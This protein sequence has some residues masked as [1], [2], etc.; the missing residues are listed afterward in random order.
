MDTSQ[1]VI[2]LI[3]FPF[4][5]SLASLSIRAIAIRRAVAVPAN[6]VLVG[7]TL[8][9]LSRTPKDPLLFKVE[10]PVIDHLLPF[11][12]IAIGIL[13]L[14]LALR[15]R[16]TIVALLA[17][18]Q[19]ALGLVFEFL[20]ASAAQ[21]SHN[22]FV[23][24]F[25]ILMAL[26][27]G[28]LGTLIASYGVGYMAEYHH[29][30]PEVKDRR[31]FFGF[32]IY[33]FLSAMF[34]LVFSNN[35]KWIYLFWEVT[36]LCSFFLIGYRNDEPSQESA[37]LALGINLL[38]GIAFSAGILYLFYHT[39]ILE[40]DRMVAEGKVYALIP[41]AL[42]A[43]AGLAKSAQMPFSSWLTA[44]MI[45]PT[46]V[47]ALLHSS[48]MVKAGVYLILKVSPLLNG[49][50]AGIMLTFVGGVT[51]L[52]ASFIAISQ[53]NAKR[54]LAYSTIS[55]LGLIVMCAGVG[56]YE[57]AWSALLLI[58]F[59]AVAKSLL[60]LCVGVV[61]YKLGSRDIEDMDFLIVRMPKVAAMMNI[62]LAGMFLAPFGMLISKAVTL[63]ALVDTHP[64]LGVI[65]AFGSGGTLFF[66]AKWMGKMITSESGLQSNEDR[67]SPWEWVTMV[68]LSGLTIAVCLLFPVI[69]HGLVD[70]Y[71]QGVYGRGPTLERLNL[72][73]IVGI[74]VSLLV[75]FPAGLL[76]QSFR[77][78]Y[79]FVGP[80]LSGGNLER[81]TFL[82]AMDQKRPV[83]SRNYYLTSIFGEARLLRIGLFL[84]A[85]FLIVMFGGVLS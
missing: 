48:T 59:H 41:A 42:L 49:T 69:T 68:S 39:G 6:L 16:R 29:H 26:I 51:F 47:S 14:Y 71:I 72:I 21:V 34:G 3:L 79:R 55:T 84:S 56:T 74:M 58:L 57:A 22:L 38:G 77:K 24:R 45:A 83:D 25:S 46:P 9:L 62:G 80:Y 37:F 7:A 53:S 13:I 12:E 17:G 67:I 23:D 28:I 31:R 11:A 75:V 19:L 65:L 61:E 35:L 30:Y 27:I 82:G 50:L 63:R 40:L 20:F 70:P 10:V 78:D 18:A 81:A 54:V 66:Y 52:L 8:L 2:F 60:F 44:A 73:L 33:L 1:I 64:L 76:Y 5:L 15:A 36:T 85:F 4:F 43:F 32:L